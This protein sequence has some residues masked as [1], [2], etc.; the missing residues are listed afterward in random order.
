MLI[1][2]QMQSAIIAIAAASIHG[3]AYH[4]CCI[5]P[6]P[7]CSKQCCLGAAIKLPVIN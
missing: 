3:F 2:T 7:G 6:A 4:S 5:V 1:V